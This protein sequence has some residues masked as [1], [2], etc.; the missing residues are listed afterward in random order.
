MSVYQWSF[1]RLF[2][3]IGIIGAIKLAGFLDDIPWGVIV[4]L[5]LLG[6]TAIGALVNPR[7]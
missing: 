7:N 5:F 3:G 6:A 4:L 2:L 1:L